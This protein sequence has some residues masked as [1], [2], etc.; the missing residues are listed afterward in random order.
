[1]VTPVRGTDILV[2]DHDIG[3]FVW[4][5]H[6]MEY[7]KINLM[8]RIIYGWYPCNYAA[9]AALYREYDTMRKDKPEEWDNWLMKTEID[10]IEEM[11]AVDN[12]AYHEYMEAV[13]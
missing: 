4:A 10:R 1:M 7:H 6:I 11:E 2:F 13:R 5:P 12:V 8:C 3:Y 9:R